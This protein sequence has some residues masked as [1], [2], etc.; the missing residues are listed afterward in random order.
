MDESFGKIINALDELKLRETTTVIFT[1][2]NGPAITGIHPHGSSGPL[3]DKKGFVTDGGIRVPGLVQS[4]GITTPGQ[5]SSTTVSGVD[6][7][8][9][10]CELA[11]VSPPSD[12]RLDGTSVVNVF[13]RK[14]LVSKLP[15][16][17]QFHRARGP[18]KVAIRDG[19][20]KMLARLNSPKLRPNG[21]IVAGEMKAMKAAQLID[22]ELYDLQEDIGETS[23]QNNQYTEVFQRMRRKMIAMHK[24]VME[25]G[26]TWPEWEFARHEGKL[27]EW[28]SYRKRRN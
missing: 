8:P 18:N 9:T 19:K 14:K 1:S 13:R 15:L 25:E 6:W 27:I 23:K 10:I 7:L 17:W 11:G 21:G 3:R 4:P 20:W 12:R 16:Y 24:E 22:F 5:V 28:P 26:P 2:D